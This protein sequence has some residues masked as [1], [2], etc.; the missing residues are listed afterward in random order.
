[1]NTRRRFIEI[2][3]FASVAFLAACG[4]KKAPVPEPVA[5]APAPA[6]DPVPAAA[7]PMPAAADPAAAPAAA[8]TE[9]DEK[10]AKAVA[11]AYVS[12]ATRTDGAKYKTYAAGQV[13][14]NCALFQGKASDASGPCPLFAGNLVAA[15]GWC[16]AYAKKTT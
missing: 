8:L 12:D 15:K 10:S 2:M 6:P 3:P 5:P 1:M 14:S 11:L 4:E 9:L 16:S 13:C 7:P